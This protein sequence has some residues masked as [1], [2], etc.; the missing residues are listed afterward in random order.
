[1]EFAQSLAVYV[2]QSSCSPLFM[3]GSAVGK[4]QELYRK[5][6]ASGSLQETA[7]I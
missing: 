6:C 7:S 2:C 1:M 3:R 5:E 4:R